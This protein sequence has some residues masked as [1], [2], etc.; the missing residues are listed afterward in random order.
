[1]NTIQ[2]HPWPPPV[3]TQTDGNPMLLTDLGLIGYRTEYGYD[4]WFLVDADKCWCVDYYQETIPLRD[5]GVPMWWAHWP[6]AFNNVNKE[7][8]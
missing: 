8:A 6:P 1:M 4:E 7:Q 3:T 5:V 2:M